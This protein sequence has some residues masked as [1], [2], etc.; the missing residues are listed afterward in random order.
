MN[1]NKL[2]PLPINYFSMVLGLSAFGL[3]CRYGAQVIGLSFFIGETLLAIA[4]TIWLWFISAY[5]YKWVAYR[6]QAQEE[7]RHPIL[8]CFVSLIPITTIL[9]GLAVLPYMAL[10]AKILIMAGIIG[11]LAFAAYRSASL[12]KGI[13]PQEATSPVLYLP[14][15]ATNFVSANALGVLGYPDWGMLFLG[16]GAISWLTLEPAVLRRFR[17][18]EPFPEPI[19]PIMGIQLAPPFVG[20]SAYFAVNGGAADIVV[21]FLIGY[22]LLQALL[23]FRLLPWIGGKGFS[24]PFW[25][26]SFGLASMAGVGLHLYVAMQG[27]FIGVLGLPMFYFATVCIGLLILNTLNLAV[28]GKFFVNK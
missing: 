11:Q 19:R 13:H 23:L 26:F 27:Q 10:P 7:L 20:C 16:A 14:T 3:A 4:G 15:V 25:A 18:V 28:K 21:K 17:N 9:I 1:D 5:V 12:W 8:G 6:K 24:M 22:G 2:F